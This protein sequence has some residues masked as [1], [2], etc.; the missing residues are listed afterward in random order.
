M[1]KLIK[2]IRPS[3]EGEDGKFS[4]RRASAFVILCLIAGMTIKGFINEYEIS[5]LYGLIAFFLILTGII[6][7]DQL[8]RFKNGDNNQ[9]SD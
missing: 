3:F 4:Y 5:A 1:R 8:I 2:Y 9:R 7:A 6:T